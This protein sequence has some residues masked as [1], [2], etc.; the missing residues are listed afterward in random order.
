M[1]KLQNEHRN[2]FSRIADST[3]AESD[4][5]AVNEDI[6]HEG[7]GDAFAV[8]EREI[9]RWKIHVNANHSGFFQLDMMKLIYRRGR[10]CYSQPRPRPYR[11]RPARN[12]YAD[13]FEL[14]R[15]Q[16]E[17]TYC[18]G[19]AW[20]PT[21]EPFLHAWTIDSARNVIDRILRNPELHSYFG[22]AFTPSWQ[23][24]ELHGPCLGSVLMIGVSF[25]KKY[26]EPFCAW[27]PNDVEEQTGDLVSRADKV[28][29]LIG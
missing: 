11:H 21:S 15:K 24:Y 14:A 4:R 13:A 29:A 23:F 19:L 9:E 1:R 20:T 28:A 17:M 18:E 7:E 10:Y 8:V 16:A 27:P 25:D 12:R 3:P 22:V 6:L 2:R 5:A 26:T